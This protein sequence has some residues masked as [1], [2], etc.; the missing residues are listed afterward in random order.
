MKQKI[1]VASSNT[2]I[3]L[4]TSIC[5]AFCQIFGKESK[6]YKRKQEKILDAANADLRN[7]LKETGDNFHLVDYRVTWSQNLS[8]TVSAL[9]VENNEINNI[10][11]NNIEVMD[12]LEKI[13]KQPIKET[14]EHKCP[15]CGAA[16][17]EDMLFCGECGEKLK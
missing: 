7:Q 5:V 1:L 16:I 9:A 17:D 14:D 13:Q 4:W 11:N 10:E 15:K 12:K 2:G 6:N 3:G 8:V